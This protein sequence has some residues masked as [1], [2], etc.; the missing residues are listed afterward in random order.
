LPLIDIYFDK[1][2]FPVKVDNI[3]GVD[4]EVAMIEM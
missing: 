3:F 1:T 4:N 2:A